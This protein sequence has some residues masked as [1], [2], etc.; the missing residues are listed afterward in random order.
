[1]ALAETKNNKSMKRKHDEALR[2]EVDISKDTVI[3]ELEKE[4][5]A[6]K[7]PHF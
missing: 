6:F 2:A 4:L 3:E 1:M 7:N 5:G